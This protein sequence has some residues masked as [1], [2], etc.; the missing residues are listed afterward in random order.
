MEEKKTKIADSFRTFLSRKFSFGSL[1]SASNRQTRPKPNKL[2]TNGM[3]LIEILV[4]IALI[5]IL[6]SGLIVILNPVKQLQKSRDANR[7]SEI[8][9]IQA[10]VELH[11]SDNSRYPGFYNF[12]NPVYGWAPVGGLAI[13]GNGV[14]YMTSIP[15]GP[16]TGGDNC[17][18]YLYAGNANNY[19]IFTILEN[20][21]DTDATSVKP[22]PTYGGGGYS[23]NGNRSWAIT[24]GSCTGYTYNYWAI[25]P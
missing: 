25:N 4:V 14:T 23:P 8:K 19:T 24:S 3:T 16:N 10:A 13:N 7:K 20:I 17:K 18:G 11:R 5:G 9:Q 22:A 21:S 12:N 15:T 6:A 1:F 2:E